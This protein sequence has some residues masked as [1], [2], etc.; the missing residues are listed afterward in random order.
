MKQ[1][2][3]RT[4]AN[5][6]NGKPNRGN[7]NANKMIRGFVNFDGIEIEQFYRD[8]FGTLASKKK[9]LSFI[10]GFRANSITRLIAEMGAVRRNGHLI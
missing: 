6:D 7:E 2:F 8:E 5:G 1:C 3:G 10:R 9:Q 4:V